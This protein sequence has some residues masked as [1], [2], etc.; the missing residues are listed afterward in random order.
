MSK[1]ITLVCL[2]SLFLVVGGCGYMQA[3]SNERAFDLLLDMHETEMASFPISGT[4]QF[5]VDPDT[6]SVQHREIMGSQLDLTVPCQLAF[7]LDSRDDFAIRVSQDGKEVTSVEVKE[8][9][10]IV[11]GKE[12]GK[13]TE[14]MLQE[15]VDL[16]TRMWPYDVVSSHLFILTGLLRPPD[17]LPVLLNS[18][19]PT[20][21]SSSDN[22]A[23]VQLSITAPV[24]N[25]QRV[26]SAQWIY[27]ID[28]NQ[29]AITSHRELINGKT[30]MVITYSNSYSLDINGHQRSIAKMSSGNLLL[31]ADCSAVVTELGE[32]KQ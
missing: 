11:D 23:L 29:E 22:P 18:G 9:I 21:S 31:G 13:L 5:S 10:I 19:V 28:V 12:F 27:Q 8:G 26:P 14:S 25:N 2:L 16:G 7:T 20:I 6:L 32:G 1:S 17:L 15:N 4:L 30:L 3:R 24:T